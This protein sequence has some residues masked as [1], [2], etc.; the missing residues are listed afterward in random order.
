MGRYFDW[1]AATRDWAC[2]V[3]TP[4]QTNGTAARAPPPRTSGSFQHLLTRGSP[5][6]KKG[7]GAG[8]RSGAGAGGG[9]GAGAT[10]LSKKTSGISCGEERAC[11][12]SRTVLLAQVS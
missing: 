10:T 3:A 9:G 4:A 5:R 8:A 7:G 2:V 12:E 11:V 1:G 6:G